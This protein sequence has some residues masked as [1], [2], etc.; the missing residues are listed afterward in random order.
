MTAE[1]VEAV[2]ETIGRQ[3][4]DLAA[5][6]QAAADALT[7]GEGEEMISQASLQDFLWY[8]LPRKWPEEAWLPVARGSAS[9]LDAIGLHRYASIARSETTAAILHAWRADSRRGFDRYRAASEASGVKPPTTNL[10]EWGSLMGMDELSAHAHLEEMLERAIVAGELRPGASGWKAS[11]AALCDRALR[12]PVPDASTDTWLS[13]VI[14]ERVRTWVSVGRPERL[15]ALRAAVAGRLMV[16][17]EPPEELE[18]VIEPIRWLLEACRDGVTATQAGYL[19]P[20][21]VHGAIER[22][23]WW[24]WPA[25]PRSESDVPQLG[26]LRETASRLRLLTKRGRRIATS[27]SGIRLLGDPVALWRVIAAGIGR[28][29]DYA[30]MVSELIAHRLLEGPAEGDDLAAAIVPIVASQ[31]WQSGGVAL[32]PG[33]IRW[34]IHGPLRHWRLFGLLD[35]RV[36]RWEN[37]RPTG[38]AITSLT[39]VGR[40]TAM[41][42]LHARAT[43]PRRDLH[44]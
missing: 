37:N 27:R 12:E 25:R 43:A 17:T 14:G 8:Y 32:D 18:P 41:A 21:L 36:P 28:V 5:W 34:S 16:P 33:Q 6:T 15:R 31:G 30:G 10:L 29:D 1:H 11:A 22:F 38:P 19:P 7:A 3:D 35:E 24:D 4:P 42:Y 44:G 39:A 2:I 20:T 13:L 9:L 40:A 26:V 23:G